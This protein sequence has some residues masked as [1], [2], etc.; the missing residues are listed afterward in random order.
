M[1]QT[2]KMS[3]IFM[4]N[5]YYYNNYNSLKTSPRQCQQRDWA[6]ELAKG[7]VPRTEEPSQLAGTRTAKTQHQKLN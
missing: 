2:L 4:V 3:N 1:G 7:T 6:T 5:I